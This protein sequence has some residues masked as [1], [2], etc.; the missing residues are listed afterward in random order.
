MPDKTWF[1]KITRRLFLVFLLFALVPTTVLTF[2]SFRY[3]SNESTRQVN[4]LQDEQVGV[5]VDSLLG[6]LTVLNERLSYLAEDEELQLAVDGDAEAASGKERYSVLSIADL[7]AAQG[8]RE[9]AF[10]AARLRDGGVLLVHIGA[11]PAEKKVYLVRAI[12]PGDFSA[13][14]AAFQLDVTSVLGEPD[15]WDL[16]LASCVYDEQSKVLFATEAGVCKAFAGLDAYRGNYRGLATTNHEGVEYYAGYKSIYLGSVYGAHDWRALVARPS[17]EIFA[18]S[19][20]FKRDFFSLVLLVVLLISLVS[21]FLIRRQMSPLGQIMAGIERVARKDYGRAVEVSSGDEFE[22]LADAFNGMSERVAHQL[23]T[24]ASM[25][26]IDQLILSRVK[27]EDII[28]IVLEQTRAVLPAD[29]IAMV[30]VQQDAELAEVYRLSGADEL[31]HTGAQFESSLRQR[32]MQDDYLLLQGT[33]SETPHY[34]T[35]T[36]IPSR[37]Y[38]QSIPVRQE[39]E[40]I[41]LIVLAF[42]QCP[43]FGE[44]DVT[45]AQNYADRIAVA[46]ANAEWEQRLYRQAHYDGLTGLPNRMSFLDR[47][48]QNITRVERQQETMGILFID[49]DNFKLV[50]DTLGHPV[51]DEFIKL[52]AA[53]FEDCMRAEDSVSR[54]GGDEFVITAAGSAD[55]ELTVASVS[56]VANRILEAAARPLTVEGHEIRASASI[57]IAIYPK[58]GSDPETLLKNADTAM[59]HAKSMGRGKF[60]FYSSELNAQL[61]ELMRLSTDIRNALEQ[62]EFELHY[63]PKVDTYSARIV[64]A[65]ALVR[66]NHPSRG[67]VRPDEFIKAAEGLGL[68]SAIGDWTLEAACRQQ[69][70]WRNSGVVPVRVAVNI[71]AVQL[72]QD[73]MF[74]KIDSLLTKYNLEGADLELEITENLLV[75]DMESAVKVLSQIRSLGV[76]VSI[77]DYGTG[78]SSLS[79]MKELPVDTLKLDSCFIIDLCEDSAD[80]AIVNSTIVL[81]RNLNMKVL[82]EGVET[83]GQLQILASYGCNEIQGHYFSQALPEQEFTALLKM[84]QPFAAPEG[85]QALADS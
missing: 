59:Y 43:E 83:E 15:S 20:E 26:E 4:R 10:P 48:G 85:S 25:S 51:G 71:S 40:L 53:R 18:A 52:V 46:L 66:W 61:L 60:Q 54:L 30:L 31:I 63:Q 37:F 50:N 14:L 8:S 41:A 73:E 33:D 13:G 29:N 42:K 62:H 57:G 49:L 1:G 21:I 9:S 55:H 17:M 65:E 45:L 6:R 69:R 36:E 2:L 81:A 82:A 76:A 56:R 11:A 79:Y 68:I 39:D 47:L 67:L 22:E 78:Y 58:D 27:K 75:Q 34:I 24:Q 5:M 70:D 32:F 16:R 3:I 12:D 38:F 84:D 80:Q 74:A 23:L 28:Q 19:E 72:Q 7:E 64:G 35:A 44:D 77:D